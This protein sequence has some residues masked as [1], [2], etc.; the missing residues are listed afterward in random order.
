MI[1]LEISPNELL[2]V[3]ETVQLTLLEARPIKRLVE[4]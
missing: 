3:L 1:P 2:Y 4:A